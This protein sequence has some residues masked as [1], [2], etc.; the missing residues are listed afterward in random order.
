MSHPVVV[1]DAAAL[2]K[3]CDPKLRGVPGHVWVHPLHL[4]IQ[5]RQRITK[6]WML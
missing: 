3:V 1:L 2:R 4:R 6:A 5:S